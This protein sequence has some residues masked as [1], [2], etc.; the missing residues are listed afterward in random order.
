M[1]EVRDKRVGCTGRAG[2]VTMVL[3][4]SMRRSARLIGEDAPLWGRHLVA[5]YM[6][7]HNGSCHTTPHHTTQREGAA[8]VRNCQ[9]GRLSARLWR[10][11]FSAGLRSSSLYNRLCWGSSSHGPWGAWNH[12][13]RKN[14]LLR[15]TLWFIMRMA[16]RASQ[17]DN[18]SLSEPPCSWWA[19]GSRGEGNVRGHKRRVGGY[20]DVSVVRSE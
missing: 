1:G 8:A 18:S 4:L 7:A 11:T 16:W 10:R 20:L 19:V 6:S 3:Y 5:A 2:S 13:W 12:S 17:S 9:H 15:V 14:G